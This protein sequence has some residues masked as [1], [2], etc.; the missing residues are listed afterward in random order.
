[1]RSSLC[2][3][4][5]RWIQNLTGRLD[6]LFP[7]SSLDFLQAHHF[8]RRKCARSLPIDYGRNVAFSNVLRMGRASTRHG[9]PEARIHLKVRN[10]S[11]FLVFLIACLERFRGLTVRIR[12]DARRGLCGGVLSIVSVML[13]GNSIRCQGGSPEEV[14]IVS[15]G[16][17]SSGSILRGPTEGLIVEVVICFFQL[18]P[19]PIVGIFEVNAE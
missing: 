5:H 6:G 8:L 15:H 19:K 18:V 11:W 4:L 13:L 1:M 3:C 2:G 16:F 7:H 10:V 12:R 14:K 9:T 17:R